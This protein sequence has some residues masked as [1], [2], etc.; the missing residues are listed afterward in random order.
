[1]TG[2]QVNLVDGD[3]TFTTSAGTFDS[4]FTIAVDGVLTSI[5]NLERDLTNGDYTIYDLSGR[6]LSKV[7]H[8][9]IYIVQKGEVSRKVFVT[10]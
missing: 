6:K 3:Y 2:K 8:S 9:G 5:T 4:R 10:K 1:M 7:E